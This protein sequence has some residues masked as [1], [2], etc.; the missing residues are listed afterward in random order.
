MQKDIESEDGMNPTEVN[1]RHSHAPASGRPLA[2][3][4]ALNALIFIIE[5]AGGILTNS[6]GLISDSLHN[7][8][9]FFALILSYVASKVV[10]WKSN[11]EKSY[12]YV[13]V[14][15]VVAFINAIVLVLIGMWV[16]YEGIQRLGS[17]VP[18]AGGWMLAVA[19]VGF[20]FN[21]AATLLLKTHAHHDLNMKS[22]YVHLLT[23]AV[24]SLAVLVVAGIIAWKDWRILDPLVS[25]AIGLF[26][27][28]SAWGIVAETVHILTEGTPRGIDLDEVAAFIQSFPGVENVHHLH[29]WGLS[30]RV[31]ALSAHI[32]VQDQL[33]SDGK[34]ISSKLEEELEHRFGIN[35]PTLQ[36]ESSVCG[37]QGIVVDFHHLEQKR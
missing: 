34:K 27:I 36:F 1:K 13:R 32:V 37:D 21:T 8:S 24:E 16:V 28:K 5:L 22:A 14:E 4:I 23:D 12:G 2:I 18:V 19:A 11:S 33:I 29:I 20:V 31:R 7:L 9:D 35:H 25:I 30:S 6:L 10:Q 3:A 17:P 26:I 15:I